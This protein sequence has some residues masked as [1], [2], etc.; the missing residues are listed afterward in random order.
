[1]DIAGFLG[2]EPPPVLYHYTTP[3]GFLGITETG[4]IWATGIHYLN[5]SQEFHHALS[6]FASELRR[7]ASESPDKNQ[8]FEWL[9]DSVKNI[10]ELKIFVC[11][12]SQDQDLLSQWRA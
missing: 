5:D 12:F 4:T 11:S 3:S 8:F 1:M 7:R 6:L 9:A 10:R 2:I